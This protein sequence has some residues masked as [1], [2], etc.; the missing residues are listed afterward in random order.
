MGNDKYVGYFRVSTKRQG[1][2]G[3]GLDAQRE[4]VS[5]FMKGAALLADYVEIESGRK[6]DRAELAKALD[7]C[8]R[9]GATLLIA[10]LDR[11]ARNV[12]FT[13]ALMEADVDF[14]A[15]DMPDANRLTIHIMACM[16]EHESRMASERTKAALKQAKARGRKLGWSIPSRQAEQVI[17]SMNG[18][19]RNKVKA[20]QH[21]DNVV[22]IIQA[23]EAAGVNT[24]QGIAVALNARGVQTARG[25]EWYA[26]T[27]KNVLTRAS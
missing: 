13:A 16:A 11:L 17:A 9:K 27:V 1:E 20:D 7:H 2:S 25:G 8:K 24:M 10:K 6:A 4:M 26:T 15:V 14:I 18:V 23:I 5:S 19:N 22:P 12:A 3:L 21:A